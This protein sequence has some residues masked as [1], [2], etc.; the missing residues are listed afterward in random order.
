MAAL[1]YAMRRY[2]WSGL[3]LYLGY[4]AARKPSLVWK[5]DGSTGKWV[6]LHSALSDEEPAFRLPFQALTLRQGGIVL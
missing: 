2:F 6:D 1:L 5:V 4:Y 3:A